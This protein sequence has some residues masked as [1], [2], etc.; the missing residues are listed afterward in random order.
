MRLDEFQRRFAELTKD[1]LEH[2]RVATA[3]ALVE[4]AGE[5]AR[6]VLDREIYRTGDDEALLDEIGDALAALAE[7][8][9]RHGLA[10]D[11]AATRV[12]DKVGERA[13]GWRRSIGTRLTDLRARWDGA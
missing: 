12:L 8:C 1:G 4:E 2:P 10:L 11:A 5:V 7:V 9:E 13:P 3:L 6:C